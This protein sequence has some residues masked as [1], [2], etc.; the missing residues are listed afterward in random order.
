M[1]M[2]KVIRWMYILFGDWEIRKVENCDRGPEKAEVGVF[3]YTDR[4]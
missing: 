4:L 1:C 2:E 3:H